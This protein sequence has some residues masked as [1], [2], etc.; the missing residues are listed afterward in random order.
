MDMTFTVCTHP[1]V[2]EKIATIFLFL[3]PLL[4]WSLSRSKLRGL[5]SAS[6]VPAALTPLFIGVGVSW[7]SVANVIGGMSVFVG[8]GRAAAAAGAADA[9]TLV[10]LSA[11][12]A[13]LVCGVSVLSDWRTRHL[14]SSQEP[15]R[16]ASLFT[17]AT[18]LLI[19]L[20]V[21]LTAGEILTL[22][23]IQPGGGSVGWWSQALSCAI[24]GTVGGCV[25]LAWLI[26]SRRY[27]SLQCHR[28][29]RWI[30]MGCTVASSLLAYG[31]WR[32]IVA[33]TVIARFG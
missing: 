7:T 26:A 9:L 18:T 28:G 10:V 32:V 11:V 13:A 23:R 22:A 29:R 31:V 27:S 15:A 1:T 3:Y 17:V 24:A 12:V 6:A 4:V 19:T 2:L 5:M 20:F 21:A 8:G 25:A 33:Y 16:P 14:R 30:A